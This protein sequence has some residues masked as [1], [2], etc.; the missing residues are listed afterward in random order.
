[1][2][3]Y[4]FRI[5]HGNLAGVSESSFDL[6]DGSAAWQEMT[7]VC[8]TMVA[9]LCRNLKPKGDWQMDLLD[10]SREPVFRIRLVAESLGQTN[11]PPQAVAMFDD[12]RS[13]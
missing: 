9:S 4:F 8:G 11:A 5:S 12:S 13:R 6:A 2:S 1:M 3:Q 7:R 10:A